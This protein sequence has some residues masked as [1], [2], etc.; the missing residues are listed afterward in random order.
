MPRYQ[1]E[2][3]FEGVNLQE[4]L[5]YLRLNQQYLDKEDL[6]ALEPFLPVRKRTGK[7]PQMTGPRVRGAR[8]IGELSEKEEH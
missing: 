7:E 5:L 6:E 4:A 1:G 8:K 3:K 2:M